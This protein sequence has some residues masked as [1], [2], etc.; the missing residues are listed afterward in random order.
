MRVCQI[1]WNRRSSLYAGHSHF[2]VPTQ[3]RKHSRLLGCWRFVGAALPLTIDITWYLYSLHNIHL[4][5]V[6]VFFNSIF[7]LTFQRS[8]R[9]HKHFLGSPSQA[10]ISIFVMRIN[11]RAYDPFLTNTMLEREKKWMYNKIQIQCWKEKKNQ[12]ITK[13]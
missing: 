8:E 9:D 10:Q 1:K 11:A 3:S 13:Y 7:S 12:C 5:H 6:T 2:Q 4:G